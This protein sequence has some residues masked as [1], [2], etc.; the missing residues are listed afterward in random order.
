MEP[1]HCNDHKCSRT[2]P[3][4]SCPVCAW[5]LQENNIFL[6]PSFCLR[7]AHPSQPPT[8]RTVCPVP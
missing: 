3:K 6:S 1:T 2:S 5:G 8:S 4:S 7:L